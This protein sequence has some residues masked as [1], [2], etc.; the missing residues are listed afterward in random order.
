MIQAVVKID[1]MAC[2]M[3]E[4][5]INDTIRKLYPSAKKVTASHKTG[6]ARFLTETA[7]EEEALKKAINDTGY[8]YISMKA[9]EKEAKKHF[10]QRGQ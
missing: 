10:W 9:T 7:P 5:H 6:E 3:C 2:G 8:T 1:G 4:A